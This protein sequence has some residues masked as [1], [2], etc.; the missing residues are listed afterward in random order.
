MPT[1]KPLPVNLSN[2][3]ID[4][5]GREMDA[6]YEETLASRGEKDRLYILRLI[7]TQRSMAL[8]GRI[9][10]YLGLLFL[11]AFSHALASWGSA[12]IVMTLGV[13]LLGIAKIL[14]NMEIAHNVLHAQWDWMKDPEIQSN[15]WEWDNMSPSDRWMHSHNVVHHTWT[16]VVGKDLDVGYGIMRVTPMQEWEPKFLMQPIWFVLLMLLFEEGVALHEQVIIDVVEGKKDSKELRPIMKHIGRKVWGQVRKD[17]IMWPLAAALMALPAAMFVSVSPISIFLLVAVANGV[18]NIIRNVWAFII[19]F[20]GHFPEGVYSFTPDQVEGESKGQWYL[21]QLLGSANIQGGPLFHV[22]SGNL[23]HQI[24]H[25]L[26]PDL[27]SNRYPELS[28]RIQAL[29]ARYGLPY[30]TASIWRQFGTTW[31]NNLR[32]ALPGGKMPP[33]VATV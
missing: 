33:K 22:L 21:R 18:A 19:I 2:D 9:L 5:F 10:I 8:G 23:S 3:Q 11:P 29:A 30:N 1:A 27:C 20:C 6:I 24:E 14:E 25:H 16:N 28:P 31:R 7:R 4:E 15:T 12:L 13:V 17:Y 32:L 26:F